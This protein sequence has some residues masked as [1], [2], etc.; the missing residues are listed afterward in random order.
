MKIRTVFSSLLL[1]LTLTAAASTPPTVKGRVE[2]VEGQTVLIRTGGT[3]SLRVDA[4]EAVIQDRQGRATMAAITPGTEVIVSLAAAAAAGELLHAS[5]ISV[6]DGDTIT[7]SGTAEASNELERTLTIAGRKVRIT[8]QTTFVNT[9]NATAPRGPALYSIA[10]SVPFAVEAR[11]EGGELVAVRIASTPLP[12]QV[13]TFGA[14][15]IEQPEPGLWI[16]RAGDGREVRLRLDERTHVTGSPHVDDFVNVTALFGTADAFALS[17]ERSSAPA[18]VR[19]PFTFLIG[20]LVKIDSTSMTIVR[21]QTELA[22]RVTPDTVFPGVRPEPGDTV[23]VYAQI[24][25]DGTHIAREVSVKPPSGSVTLVNRVTGIEGSEWLVAGW[26]I[27]VVAT[28]VMQGNPGVGD[29]V[30]V[31]A[32][33]TG[34]NRAT[35]TLIAKR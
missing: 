5:A 7:L 8:D 32:M 34:K 26:R 9:L 22:L 29:I 24:L 18:P 14:F 35:A 33:V 28:T 25:P 16:V 4:G 2:A 23:L 15:L 30:Y 10:R 3:T 20:E 19:V 12:S 17:V 13:A 1:A 27:A 31:E 21:G 6:Y 11:E